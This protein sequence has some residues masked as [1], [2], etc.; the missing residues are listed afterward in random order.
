MESHDLVK[1][2]GHFGVSVVVVVVLFLCIEK[3]HPSQ[4]CKI[5]QT[6]VQS[7]SIFKV[8][9]NIF[10]WLRKGKAEPVVTTQKVNTIE[11]SNNFFLHSLHFV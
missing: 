6:L 8:I 4:M 5:I 10:T 3:W 11:K 1:F 9:S 2:C 7:S